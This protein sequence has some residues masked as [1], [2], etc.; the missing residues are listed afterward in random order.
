[1][2]KS[3]INKGDWFLVEMIVKIEP[4]DND[5]FRESR[6]VTTWGNYYLFNAKT[7][8]Q[9]YNKGMRDG[10]YNNHTYKDQDGTI[11]KVE[12]IGI[13][14][15]LPVYENIED[16]AEILWHDYGKISA[17]RSIGLVKTKEELLAGLKLKRK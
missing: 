11:M 12:F 9:A 13:G 8:L 6:R 17:R 3:I 16:G 15:L 14:D 7:P 10:K 5:T 2:I 4:L 1:M